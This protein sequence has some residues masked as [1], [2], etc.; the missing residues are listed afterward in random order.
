MSKAITLEQ[1]LN[2]DAIA[3]EHDELAFRFVPMSSKAIVDWNKTQVARPGKNEDHGEFLQG[4][5]QRQVELLAAHMRRCVVT[6][7]G[8]RVTSEWVEEHFPQPV[9]KELAAFFADGTRPDW[10]PE[11]GKLRGQNSR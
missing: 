3:F 9:L 5:M 11:V 8:E 4:V 10:A 7:D 6:G 2:L 1:V